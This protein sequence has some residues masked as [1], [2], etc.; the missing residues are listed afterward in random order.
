MLIIFAIYPYF[1]QI[2]YHQKQN[3]KQD[4]EL[5]SISELENYLNSVTHGLP[6]TLSG[7]DPCSSNPCRNG[8]CSQSEEGYTCNCTV[9][10]SGRDCDKGNTTS[11]DLILS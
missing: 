6:N 10:F 9:G 11:I 7:L 5:Y 3:C 1:V 8:S 4:A 2:S